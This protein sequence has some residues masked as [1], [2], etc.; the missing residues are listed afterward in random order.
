MANFVLRHS[1]TKVNDA[2][3]ITTLGA[4]YIAPLAPAEV[5]EKQ[6]GLMGVELFKEETPCGC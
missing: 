6:D 2:V 3:L 4:R 1:S 5:M